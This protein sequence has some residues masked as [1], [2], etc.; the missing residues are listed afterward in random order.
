MQKYNP[1]ALYSFRYDRKRNFKSEINMKWL[2]IKRGKKQIVNF[3]AERTDIV[4]KL[5][6][7]SEIFLEGT[8]EGIH[9]TFTG[10]IKEGE[11]FMGKVKVNIIG[12]E[13]VHCGLAIIT[14]E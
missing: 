14:I 3:Y 11:L 5:L 10:K 13:Q 12:V 2:S 7:P 4:N 6:V 8:G 1:D 9:A